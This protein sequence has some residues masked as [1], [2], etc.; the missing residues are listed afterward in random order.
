MNKELTEKIKQIMPTLQICNR[1]IEK[2]DFII[3]YNNVID[4]LEPEKASKKEIR[5]MFGQLI[6][7]AYDDIDMLIRNFVQKLSYL[8]IKKSCLQRSGCK[9]YMALTKQMKMSAL[10]L[11]QY[12][13]DRRENFM[14]DLGDPTEYK[15]V[16]SKLTFYIDLLDDEDKEYNKDSVLGILQLFDE[17]VLYL[18]DIFNEMKL[19]D[20]CMIGQ[21]NNI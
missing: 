18:F 13:Y 8:C 7:M 15:K 17:V 1:L 11:M 16:V 9:K 3:K 6:R 10:Q 14:N 21:N 2:Y 20:T 19:Y 12:L 4:S 5:L